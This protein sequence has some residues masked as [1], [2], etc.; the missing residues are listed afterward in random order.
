MAA[1]G[2]QVNWTGAAATIEGGSSPIP[3]GKVRSCRVQRGSRRL[4]GNA[5]TDH[6]P[7]TVKTIGQ[8][9]SLQI[10]LED[11]RVGAVLEPGTRC[12]LVEI[13][14]VDAR[15]DAGHGDITYSMTN[16]EVG[17]G[18]VTGDYGAW[19][20]VTL[21]FYGESVDGVTS[22]LGITVTA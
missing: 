5:D 12:S 14:N 22:P 15:E 7:T 4:T 8:E 19:S 3:L 13:T 10:V 21:G 11:T 16:A 18:D 6:Y 1:A 2:R 9:P 17:D 20:N